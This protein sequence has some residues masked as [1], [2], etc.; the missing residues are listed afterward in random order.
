VIAALEQLDARR[1]AER[2]GDERDIFAHELFLQGD[3]ACRNHDSLSGTQ[4]RHEIRERLSDARACFH[5][6]VH[7][8]EKA[9]LDQLCHL[10]LA[11]ARFKAR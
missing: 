2:P 7:V 6:R 8:L 1:N 4:R 3:R 9:A 10:H 11:R 5:D